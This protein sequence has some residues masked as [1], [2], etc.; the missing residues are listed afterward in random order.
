MILISLL[1]I[2]CVNAVDSNITDMELEL[3]DEIS[4]EPVLEISNDEDNLEISN[5]AEDNL[6]IAD[7]DEA[8]SSGVT[9]DNAD[10]SAYLILDNDAD[11]EN[12]YL[13]DQVVWIVSVINMGPDT[14]KNVKVFDQLPDG[15]KY[16][17]HTLTK[18]TFDPKTGIW[19]IGDL[20]VEDGEVFLN[21]TTL[22]ISV[23]EKI[24]KANLTTDS[25]NLNNESYEEEEIDVFD[26]DDEDSDKTVRAATSM[27]PTGNPLAM[28]LISLFMIFVTS[29]KSKK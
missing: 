4:D 26:H 29:V 28:V 5:D 27:H 23:G 11:I 2:T 15:L 16:V 13:G 8:L 25:I 19:D 22:A 10:S 21:I 1:S 9:S 7:D 17:S 6:Q 14:A 3:K 24:N 12:I 20:S 18:G